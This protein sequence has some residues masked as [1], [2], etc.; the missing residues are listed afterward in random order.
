MW[1]S[2]NDSSLVLSLF[3]ISPRSPFCAHRRQQRRRST[4]CNSDSQVKVINVTNLLNVFSIIHV[5]ARVVCAGAVRSAKFIVVFPTY[6]NPCKSFVWRTCGDCMIFQLSDNVARPRKEE[7]KNS[8]H[9]MRR[10]LWVESCDDDGVPEKLR[11]I[12]MNS[13]FPD[14]RCEASV[15]FS[16]M[17]KRLQRRQMFLEEIG[18]FLILFIS[19]HTIL[20]LLL[21]L[22]VVQFSVFFPSSLSSAAAT[23]P[24]TFQK[25]K[26]L[27][28]I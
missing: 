1:K 2:E 19:S 5:G 28:W 27:S 16:G 8:K 12:C 7:I 14:F 13:I 20:C 23:L 22:C 21:L 9:F 10:K 17:G 18:F 25:H 24:S 4:K 3:F 11:N 26:F 6:Q 15:C